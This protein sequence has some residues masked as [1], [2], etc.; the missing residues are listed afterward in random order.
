MQNTIMLL[1]R[2]TSTP[3]DGSAWDDEAMDSSLIQQTPTIYVSELPPTTTAV[4]SQ[5]LQDFSW[6]SAVTSEQVSGLH[7]AGLYAVSD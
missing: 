1:Y 6:T 5:R 2:V 3:D 4:T 7:C